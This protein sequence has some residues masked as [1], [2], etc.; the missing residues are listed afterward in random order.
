[1]AIK[2]DYRFQYTLSFIVSIDDL[3]ATMELLLSMTPATLVPAATIT[4]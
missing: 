3:S 2:G 1:M 4:P